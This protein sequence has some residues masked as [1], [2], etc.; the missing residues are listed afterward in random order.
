[1]LLPVPVSWPAEESHPPTSGV[2][3]GCDGC[4]LA[5]LEEYWGLANGTDIS[6]FDQLRVGL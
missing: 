2:E 5:F 3:G 6:R 1:M 4:T